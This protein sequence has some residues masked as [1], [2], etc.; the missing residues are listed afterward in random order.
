MDHKASEKI[1]QIDRDLAEHIDKIVTEKVTDKL[2]AF[3]EQLDQIQSQCQ[4]VAASQPNNRATLV[5][6]SGDMDKLIATFIIATGAASMGM[7]VSVYVTFWAL[8][9]L[10]KKTCFKGKPFTDVL[11]ALMLPSG[12]TRLNSSKLNMLGIG[13]A[14]FSYVMKKKNIAS[15]SELIDLAREMGVRIIACQLAMEVMGIKPEELIDGLDFGGVATYLADARDSK[16]TLF[17]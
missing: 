3:Q 14:F 6:F 2:N 5:A 7:E 11:T 17:I 13:P 10:K 4:N 9:A 12:P 15:L 8:A 1:L 16:V